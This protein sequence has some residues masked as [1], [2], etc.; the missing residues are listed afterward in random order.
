MPLLEELKQRAR[1]LKA[2]TF[3]LYFAARHPGTPWYAK[4]FV[5]GIVA[6]AF[7]PIDVIPDFV[8]I[9]GYLDDL[10]LLPMGIA[11][12]I[13]M[14]P[15]PVWLECRA[16]AQ[17]VML[18]GKPVSHVAGAVIVVLWVA[19]AALGLLWA[20][21]AYLSVPATPHPA[22]ERDVRQVVRLSPET[23]GSRRPR[24]G[25]RDGETIAERPDPPSRE[26]W[27]TDCGKT[28]PQLV[29][30]TINEADMPILLQRAAVC[31][32]TAR[33]FCA[34]PDKP[35]EG[36]DY[37][38]RY[39]DWLLDLQQLY[40]GW[41]RSTPSLHELAC[42]ARIPGKIDISGDKMIDLWLKGEISRI[43]AYNEFDALTTFL[44]WLRTV[45]LAGLISADEADAEETN[46]RRYLTDLIARGRQ[47]LDAYVKKWDALH[48]DLHTSTT[49]T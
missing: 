15:P 45:R 12:A 2:E 30:F 18:H 6:Y 14:I 36:R 9:L 10:V 34:R 17:A 4:L 13:K 1:R 3:A 8:P 33:N 31:G 27:P 48:H 32:V 25:R 41:G 5:V 23:G 40:G 29:G 26:R 39:S 16:R 47:Y 24:G 11:L 43:V 22:V 28:K 38:T 35:W 49:S 37:F 21:K 44:L 7:S 42:A 19:L 46:L 20:S